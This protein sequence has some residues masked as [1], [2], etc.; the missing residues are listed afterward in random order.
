MDGW[1]EQ[2]HMATFA[3]TKTAL[4]TKDLCGHPLHVD[5]MS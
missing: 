1:V 4:S 5:P 3:T 2:V